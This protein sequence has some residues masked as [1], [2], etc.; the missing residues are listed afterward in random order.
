MK[1]S[2][3]K[4]TGKK[5]LL[6]FN[7]VFMIFM[8][9][10][11]L[12]DGILS[13]GWWIRSIENQW[14]DARIYL[15][16]FVSVFFTTGAGDYRYGIG[17]TY[18][19]EADPKISIIAIDGHTV[20]KYGYPF[21]RK[22][23]ARLIEKLTGLG[24]GSIGFDVMFFDKDREDPAS[25]RLFVEA[26]KKAGNVA[27]LVAMDAES[28]QLLYPITGLGEAS[29][30]IS[31][32][33]VDNTLESN[34]QVR[35]VTLF[36]PEIAYKNLRIKSRCTSECESINLPLLAVATY[37]MHAKKPL[38]E[39]EKERGTDPVFIN[40]R[41]PVDRPSHP[42]WPE[43]ER[44]GKKS[45]MQTTNSVY[46]YVSVADILEN[47]LSKDEKAAIKDGVMLVGSTALGAF[48]HYPSVFFPTWPGVEVHANTIDNLRNGDFLK[49]VS[50][51]L[52]FAICLLLMWLPA[53]MSRY[54]I[55]TTSFIMAG[56]VI[57]LAVVNF[58]LYLRLYNMAYLTIV[59][60]LMIPFLFMTVH[61]AI[62]EGREKKWIKNTFGQYLS[63]KIVEVI[64]RDP[65][66]LTL[67]GEKRDMTAFF[68]DIAGFTTMSEKMTPE[69]LTQ[70]LNNYLSGFT[71]VILKHDGV[72]DK[73]IGDCIMAFW[74]AP[75]D[76]KDH[77][78]LAC[79][80]AVDCMGEITRLNAELTQFNVKPSARIG[81]NSGPMVV[82][83]MG[84]K[85][86]L[87]YTVMGD[88][89]NLA[90]RLEGANKFFHSRIMASEYTYD[91]AKDFVEARSLGQ[92]R[93]VGKAIPVKVYELLARK[94]GL[95]AKTA[96]LAA[97]YNEGL[98][99]FYK[100]AYEKAQ[101]AFKAALAV[102]PKDGP[103]AFYLELAEKYSEAAP[104]DWDGTFNL[105]SK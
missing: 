97:A 70:M 27:A 8:L 77:R 1:K 41:V 16:K 76:Q 47:R 94:G 56:I 62:V 4:N 59:I 31:Y 84:S 52:I 73:Y 23:Y 99:H 40:F 13:K 83:N 32:P 71:D 81:L 85:M 7:T 93:V 65:S 51:W 89:V 95:D 101:K 35:K 3:V 14:T 43:S 64:T 12:L 15:P 67:G 20:K 87:S 25:D 74:N 9:F 98:E 96:G 92:I 103:S 36:N 88:S 102:E 100:S 19:K 78:K 11:F 28:G 54:S 61:K 69:Q 60:S 26:V 21:K 30:Y 66:K 104:G 5:T 55:K 68:L 39:I 58:A 17:K 44:A 18:N 10:S 22:Y 48:D 105:T 57:L 53:F 91:E 24:A 75:L 33:N 63:P 45:E 46:R 90:S 6:I 49:P 86:R 34:G 42:G 79:L 37:A 50:S 82:G 2:A 38:P 29:R 72:V 80:A